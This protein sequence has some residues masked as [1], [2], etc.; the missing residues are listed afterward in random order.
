M[1]RAIHLRDD[2]A[3]FEAK[4][5]APVPEPDAVQDVIDLRLKRGIDTP[6]LNE[7]LRRETL[8]RDYDDA[9]LWEDP[10]YTYTGTTTTT[11]PTTTNTIHYETGAVVNNTAGPVTYPVTGLTCQCDDC[12]ARRRGLELGRGVE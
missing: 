8:T 5:A 12:R 1:S 10:K 11:V 7:L 9:A 6:Y 3:P 2:R 4:P